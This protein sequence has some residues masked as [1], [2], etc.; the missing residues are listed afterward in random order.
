M[1]QTIPLRAIAVIST[2]MAFSISGHAQCTI[3]LTAN[4]QIIDGYGFS[5]AWCGT[6]SSAKNN[7]LYNTL[8]MSLLRVRIDQNNFWT[9]EINNANA[10][11]AAGARVFGAPWYIPNAFRSG[12]TIPSNQYVNFCNW[13]RD[14]G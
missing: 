1:K 5:S 3:N 10:A 11:H 12:N 6:L 13:L 4:Q 14:A 8:G 2:V 9:E 7:A